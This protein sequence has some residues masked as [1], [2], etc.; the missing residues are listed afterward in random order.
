M[1]NMRASLGLFARMTRFIGLGYK[2]RI[3]SF[4]Q[5]YTHKCALVIKQSCDAT[6]GNISQ[7]T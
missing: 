3:I 2:H 1:R 4:K 6:L 7:M 5:Y